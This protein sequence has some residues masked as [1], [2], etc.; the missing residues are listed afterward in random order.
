M[1]VHIGHGPTIPP[2]PTLCVRGR[3]WLFLS[4]LI[5]APL[6]AEA[7]LFS[8]SKKPARLIIQPSSIDLNGAKDQQ[9]LL[10]TGVM[11]D[12]TEAD[13]TESAHFKSKQPGIVS[14]S[15]NGICRPVSDG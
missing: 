14:V 7:G 10:V 3:Q 5:L 8:S 13:V 9:G 15:T 12:G 4:F 11:Q 2:A 6:V 1:F